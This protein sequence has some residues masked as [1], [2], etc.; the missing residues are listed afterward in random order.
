[1]IVEWIFIVMIFRLEFVWNVFGK[2][3]IFVKFFF[4]LI[5]ILICFL[6]ESVVL[7]LNNFKLDFGEV[8]KCDYVNICLFFLWF[9]LYLVMCEYNVMDFVS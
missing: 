1:M 5:N 8:F 9:W 2:I 6:K 3:E 7:K 4:F